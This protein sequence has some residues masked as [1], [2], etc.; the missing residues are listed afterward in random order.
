MSTSDY[1]GL[2]LDPQSNDLFLRADGNLAIVT[3]AEAISQHVRQRL[4]TFEGE[5]FLDKEA[6]IPWFDQLLGKRYNPALAEAV[7]KAE[8]LNTQGVA[9]I[10]SFS[11]AF[12][13]DVRDLQIRDVELLTDYDERVQP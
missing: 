12:A 7:V 10:E 1:I 6:G 2:A 4:K 3:R 5:W 11:V 13:K 8:I 9:S